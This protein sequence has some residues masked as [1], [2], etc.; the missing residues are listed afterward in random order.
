M[1]VLRMAATMNLEIEQMDM[2]TVF[3]H[4]DLEKDIYIEQPERFRVKGK[5]DMVYK[6]RK[7]LYRLKQASQ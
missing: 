4:G 2:K 1:I 7:S 6:L 5:E 3:L